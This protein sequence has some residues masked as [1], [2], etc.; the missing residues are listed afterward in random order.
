MRSG[1]E[2]V[3]STDGGATMEAFDDAVVDGETPIVEEARQRELM[4]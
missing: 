4:V 2:V 1:E 3:P